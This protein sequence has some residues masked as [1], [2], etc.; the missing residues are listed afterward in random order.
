MEA[1]SGSRVL[2]ITD[3]KGRL[4]GKILADMG[5]EVIRIEKPGDDS[6]RDIGSLYFNAGKPDVSLDIREEIGRK[7]F[8]QLVKKSDVL[9]ESYRAGYLDSLGLGCQT[10]NEINP[11]IIVVSITD[12][13]QD[14]PYCDYNGSDLVAQALGGW[15]SVT[16]EPGAPL[17]LYDD[18]AYY[19]AS[20]FAANAVLLA[21]WHRHTTG[22]GQHIDIS[23]MEC[24]AA[25][26]DQVPVRYFSEGIVSGRP[27]SRHWNNAFRVFP[28][29]DG[30]M[31][32]SLHQ[33]WETLVELLDSEGMAEDLADVKWRDREIRDREIDHIIEVLEKWTQRHTAGELEEL[34]QLMRLPWSTVNDLSDLP[35]NPHF[36]A[37]GFFKEVEFRGQKYR[38]PGPVIRI[39]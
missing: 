3:R 38:V 27:G 11:G 16:G 4:A 24:V 12:F 21:L 22:R 37:R 33:G 2:D 39:K 35:E 9:L 31:L 26:L 7:L 19:T 5:A 34:G 18:Q 13:G 23:V 1:L 25:T 17:K 6:S 10:I 8:R 36:T 32:L 29:R 20:L 30:Y 14:G 28:C 15:L